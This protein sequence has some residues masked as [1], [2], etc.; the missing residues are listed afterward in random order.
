MLNSF[1]VWVPMVYQVPSINT[2]RVTVVVI[3][4]LALVLAAVTSE[5][6]A[7]ASGDE[8]VRLPLVV[9]DTVGVRVTEP[10]LLVYV[11]RKESDDSA[12]TVSKSARLRA[13]RV[14]VILPSLLWWSDLLTQDRYLPRCL[15][16]DAD[17]QAVDPHDGDPDVGPDDQLLVEFSCEH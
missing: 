5:D 13:V 14:V 12:A 8:T 11:V 6:S 1:I 4:V 7:V 2:S 10:L 9:D 3:P 17:L 16:P 15:D